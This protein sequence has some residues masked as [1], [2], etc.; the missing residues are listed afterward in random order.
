VVEIEGLG[1]EDPAVDSA[2]AASRADPKTVA[3][4]LPEAVVR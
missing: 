3:G 1:E 2:E 4:Q